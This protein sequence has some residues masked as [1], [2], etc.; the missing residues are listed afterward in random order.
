MD[1]DDH[2]PDIEQDDQRQEP[3]FDP[4]KC[5]YEMVKASLLKTG[6]RTN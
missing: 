1:K 5:I 2:G 3:L 6:K 4:A